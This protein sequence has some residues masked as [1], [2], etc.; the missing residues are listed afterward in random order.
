MLSIKAVTH[1]SI[2]VN[3]LA[4]SERFYGDALG[5][6]HLGRLGS[7]KMSCFT[8]GGHNILL[9]QRRTAK[10]NNPDEDSRLH[11]AFEVTPE[12]WDKAVL[13]F[14]ELG[15]RQAEPLVYRETGYFPGREMH[16]LD[17]S[18]NRIE[19]RDATWQAGMP[20]PTYEE[21]VAAAGTI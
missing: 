20:A 12:E 3:D 8:V 15:V 19:I 11:H 2:A 17:P 5:M 4:E 16:V 21:I 13:L 18:G 9:C 10:P 6:K 14:H 1:W 7:G